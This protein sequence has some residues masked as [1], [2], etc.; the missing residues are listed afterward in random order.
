M[1]NKC[2]VLLASL[3]VITSAG[4]Q[5]NKTLD[6]SNMLIADV[7]RHV[8]HWITPS[9]LLAEM[10]ELNIGWA[11]AVSAPYGPWNIQSYSQL[12]GK[13]YIATTGQTTITDIHRSKGVRGIEDAQSQEYKSLVVDA[14]RLFEAG[15]I[16]G[17][18]ELILNNENT[19]PNPAVRRKARLDSP[20]PSCW[21]LRSAGMVLSKFMQKTMPTQSRNLKTSRLNIQLCRSSCHIVFLQR[22][23]RSLTDS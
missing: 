7:H 20:S 2:F 19:N 17:L 18:G 8:Q 6:H 21:T 5:E 16:K 11:G 3:C 12:L 23:L 9:S 1:K 15:E 4:A 10:D 13:R 14:N 22:T